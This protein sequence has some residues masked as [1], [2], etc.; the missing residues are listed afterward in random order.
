MPTSTRVTAQKPQCPAALPA[1]RLPDAPAGAGLEV[2]FRLSATAARV[3]APIAPA[4]ASLP[5]YPM[6]ARL[7]GRA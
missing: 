2:A 6:S 5:A 1:H 7:A 3:L 4:S